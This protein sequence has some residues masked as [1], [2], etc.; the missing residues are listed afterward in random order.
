MKNGHVTMG[1]NF[2]RTFVFE[3]ST[4]NKH[5]FAEVVPQGGAEAIGT[6]YVA[7][8]VCPSDVEK[9]N[10]QVQVE[11]LDADEVAGGL[12]DDDSE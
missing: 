4:K 10:L 9:R 1:E 12:A 6:L 2:T 5:R 3:R 7:K 8:N 11:F